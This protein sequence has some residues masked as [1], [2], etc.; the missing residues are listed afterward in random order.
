MNFQPK[1]MSFSNLS[2]FT[3][4]LPFFFYFFTFFLLSPK[5]LSWIHE[6]LILIVTKHLVEAGIVKCIVCL[7]E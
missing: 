1:F 3:F 6:I 2:L 4:F 5:C 7:Q